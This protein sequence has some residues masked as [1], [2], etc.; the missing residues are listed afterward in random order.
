MWR[1][2]NV[3]YFGHFGDPVS[4]FCSVTSKYLHAVSMTGKMLGMVCIMTLLKML[5][6]NSD[7][8]LVDLQQVF[9]DDKHRMCVTKTDIYGL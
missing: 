1:Y 6:S 3:P 4:H 9:A 5:L 8:A 2:I 7:C